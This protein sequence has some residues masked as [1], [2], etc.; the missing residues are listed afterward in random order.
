MAQ[1]LLH[2][3]DENIQTLNEKERGFGSALMTPFESLDEKQKKVGSGSYGI[4]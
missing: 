2:S 3:Q 4:V 1:A